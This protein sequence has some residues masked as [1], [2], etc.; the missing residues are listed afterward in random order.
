[1]EH[2]DAD[3]VRLIEVLQDGNADEVGRLKLENL[4][5]YQ[6]R[7]LLKLI[8]HL[9]SLYFFWY[10]YQSVANLNMKYLR[11]AMMTR[12]MRPAQ[13]ISKTVIMIAIENNQF[14]LA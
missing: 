12:E 8:Q 4:Q 11:L 5:N 7:L 3:A 14:P 1:M 10:I 13:H 2:F 6:Q 9:R